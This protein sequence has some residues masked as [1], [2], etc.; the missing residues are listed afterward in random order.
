MLHRAQVLLNR[1]GPTER[2]R[3]VLL[4]MAQGEV[5][6]QRRPIVLVS[7]SGS[8]KSTFVAQLIQSLRACP[9]FDIVHAIFVGAAEG[10]TSLFRVL[11]E[12]CARLNF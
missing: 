10:S 8:G 12:L 7:R 1:N 9:D 11:R 4:A 6:A 2:M 3:Q 5:L